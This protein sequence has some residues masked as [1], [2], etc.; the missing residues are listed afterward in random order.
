MVRTRKQTITPV[1]AGQNDITNTIVEGK[2]TETEK[3]REKLVKKPS[4]NRQNRQMDGNSNDNARAILVKIEH[5]Q[6]ETTDAQ[7]IES[8][9]ID[10]IYQFTLNAMQSGSIKEVCNREHRVESDLIEYY[11]WIY[12]LG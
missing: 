4:S 8:A 10:R 12:D 3:E 11:D 1:D 2:S 5:K 9:T 6:S 7:E